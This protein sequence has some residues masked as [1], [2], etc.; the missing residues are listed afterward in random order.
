[1]S[2][3]SS[4]VGKEDLRGWHGGL[5]ENKLRTGDLAERNKLKTDT[6][7]TIDQ[8]RADRKKWQILAILLWVL[9]IADCVF[10]F[11]TAHEPRRWQCGLRIGDHPVKKEVYKEFEPGTGRLRTDRKEAKKSK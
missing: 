10:L 7:H 11:K 6:Q 2:H 3:D 1:M 5:A 8:I 9:T 4:A